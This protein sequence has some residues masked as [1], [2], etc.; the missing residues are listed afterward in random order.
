M[1]LQAPSTVDIVDSNS[2]VIKIT[3]TS[4]IQKELKINFFSSAEVKILSQKYI[5]P[6]STTS[7]QITL[8]YPTKNYLEMESKLEVYLDNEF[9]EKMITQKFYP[10]G[11]NVNL[12]NQPID[13]SGE[14]TGA[15]FGLAAMGSLASFGVLEWA[16]FIILVIVAAILLITLAARTLKVKKRAW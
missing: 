11:T 1:T 10:T 14:Y 15:L 6:H 2:F 5:L 9:E 3:N 8:N 7:A 12:E 13:Q 4:N 16:L